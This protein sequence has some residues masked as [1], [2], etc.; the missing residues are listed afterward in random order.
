MWDPADDAWLAGFAD[1]EASFL[2]VYSARPGNPT[3]RRP[4]LAPRF[5]IGLR[6]D[7]TP[8]LRQLANAFG[9]RLNFDMDGGGA[10]CRWVVQSKH[11]L[12]TLV[13]YFE[14]FPLR[15]KKAADYAVW[16]EAVAIYVERGG[17]VAF[18]E[19]EALLVALR[20]ARA[21]AS[22]A[23]VTDLRAS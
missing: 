6:A 1:G 9:G 11:D 23:T 14:R 19:L 21:Y 15:A 8:V 13:S 2:I 17:V 5:T 4:G 7:D 3:G 18:R 12:L 16:R 20:C 22:P 10:R